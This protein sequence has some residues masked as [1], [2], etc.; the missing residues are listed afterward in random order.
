NF[1]A[2]ACVV[3]SGKSSCAGLTSSGGNQAWLSEELDNTKQE[4]L[5][6]AQKNYMVYNYC[7]DS[8][9]FPQALAMTQATIRQLISDGIAAALEALAATMENTDNPNRNLG[10]KENHVA[11]RGNYKDKCAEEDRVTFATGTL[12]NDALSWWNAYAQPIG[13]EQA[14]KIAWTEL[15]RLLTNKSIEGN[16]TALKSQTLEEVITITQRLM[17]QN[18][19]QEAIRAYV[20][21]P[22]KN[23]WHMTGNKSYLTN[24]EEI[25][26]G[27]VAFGDFKLT[28]KSH[29]LLKVSRKNNMYN[30]DLKNVVPQREYPTKNSS[31]AFSSNLPRASTVNHSFILQI[32]LRIALHIMKPVVAGNQSNGSA[33]TKACDNVGK[34]RVETLPDNDYTLLPLWTQDPVFS[35]SLKDFPCA[36]FKPSGEE[37]K[38]DAENPGND[39]S[40]VPSIKEPR[41]NQEKDANVNNTNNINIVSPTGNAVGIKDNSVDE[42]IVNGCADDLNMPDLEEIGKFGDAE[43]DDSGAN[44]NNLDTYIQ[45]SLVPTTRIH[46]DHSLEQ[47]IRDLHSA[48]QIRRMNKLDEKR[49]GIR[50]K[51]RLA[52]HGHT[53]EEGIDYDEV[54]APVAR[55]EA[56]MKAMCTEFEKT[57]HKKFQMSSMG[58]LTFFLGLQVKQKEDGIFISQ[59]MYVNEILNTF[60]FSNVK[61]VSTPMETHK[62]LLKDEKGEDVDEHLYR[63]MIGSLMYLTSSWPDIMFACKKLIVVANS[64]TEAEYVA[65]L[66]CCGQVLWIQNQLLDYGYN[67]MQTKIH[68]DNES[69]IFIVKNP[70]FH[71]KT[72]HIEIRHHFIRDSNEKKLIQMIKIYNDNNIANLLTKAFDSTKSARFEKIIDFLNAHPIKYAFTINPTIYTLCV[73]QF[74]ATANVKNINREAQLHTKVDG[75]KVV[76]S[77]ASIKRDLWFGDE[78][79]INCLPNETIFEQL[80]LVGAKTTAWNEFSST[81]AS[82]V[83]CLAIDQ[84]FNFS[85]YIFDSMVK[86]LDGATKFLMFPRL[87]QEKAFLEG[88]HSISNYDGSS[89]RGIRVL[90]LETAKTAQAKEIANLK[91]RVKRLERKRKSR[92]HMLKRSYKVGLS[93]RVESSTDEESLDDT[94]MFDADMDLQ[95]EEVVVVEEVNAASIATTT[96]A[97]TT[98]TISMDEIIL[99]KMKFW[100]LQEDICKQERLRGE[101]ARQEEEGNSYYRPFIVNFS[102][103]AK[104]FASLTHKTQKYEWGREQEEAFQTLKDNLCNA[105]ILSLPDGPE[106]FVVY[107]D[108]SNQGLGCVL[109]LR[110]KS[111]TFKEEN[112]TTTILHGLDQLIERKEDR[113]MYFIW[114]L[115][116]GDVRILIIN[117]AHASRYLVHLGANKMYYDLRDMY[118]GHV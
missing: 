98:P 33:G 63:S 19:R 67:F 54:F 6:W 4:R 94:L 86:N 108:V 68:I 75:K 116:I 80:S 66:S 104:R 57:M 25:N 114:V 103:I 23:S 31:S 20:V 52:A 35:S 62:T 21:N 39:D 48:P 109:M 3:A 40:E 65:A 115:L 70:V 37:E 11:K 16:V 88:T 32:L 84:K 7:S 45:V 58:E 102:K 89:S 34:T 8:K 43:N 59:D 73:E 17:E 92:S 106:D 110:G 9:R 72:K 18:K 101:R 56:I 64:I 77:K 107:C 69:T 87:V 53:R 93:A 22:T 85:K 117:E 82:V 91:K 27:F 12:T 96:T 10:S 36:G 118:C 61:T 44:M 28:D 55:I 90:N 113:G 46:K 95:G 112:A 30:V 81:I 14:N 97:A 74:W 60:V 105:S 83:I 24:Y 2:N 49:I 100:K 71:S 47:V 38:K 76:I 13:I 79:G 26:G 41:V 15:K 5:R 29:V 99:A 42:N 78:G 50:N 1:K 111:E 51:E